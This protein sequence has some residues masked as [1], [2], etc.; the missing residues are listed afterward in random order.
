MNALSA[1]IAGF[2]IGGII[3]AI[4]AFLVGRKHP[5]LVATVVD[6]AKKL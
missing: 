3:C 6:T 5:A 2:A 4:A 1:F